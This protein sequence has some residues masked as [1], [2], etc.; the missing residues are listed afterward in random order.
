MFYLLSLEITVKSAKQPGKGDTRL[1]AG[2]FGQRRTGAGPGPFG[3][4]S[5]S[6]DLPPSLP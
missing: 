2:P 1:A 6:V 3:D 4:V 5:N